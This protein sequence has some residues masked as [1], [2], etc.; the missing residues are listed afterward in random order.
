MSDLMLFYATVRD[1]PT[2]REKGE[3]LGPRTL[4]EYAFFL[5]DARGPP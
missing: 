4:R 2:E 3:H 1:L 5:P